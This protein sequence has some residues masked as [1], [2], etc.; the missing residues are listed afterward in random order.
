[1]LIVFECRTLLILFLVH[2]PSWGK[3][4]INLCRMKRTHISQVATLCTNEFLDLTTTSKSTLKQER[5]W[6]CSHLDDNVARK[7]IAFFVVTAFAPT[8]TLA[9]APSVGDDSN[10]A[11]EVVGFVEVSLS[12]E[13]SHELAGA[14]LPYRPQRPKIASLVVAPSHRSGGLGRALVAAC[15][16]QGR[17]WTGHAELFLDVRGDNTVARAFYEKLGF[18][19]C[20]QATRALYGDGDVSSGDDTESSIKIYFRNDE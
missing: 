14:G 16:A 2:V 18:R 5:Q 13:A 9:T 8:E 7:N 17:L 10:A 12:A 20:P 1:M 3:K 6:I 4:I 19:L 15:A 11:P